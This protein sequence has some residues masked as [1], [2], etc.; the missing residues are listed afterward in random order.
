M[1]ENSTLFKNELINALHVLRCS[2]DDSV[3]LYNYARKL[4]NVNYFNVFVRP[5][6]A[7]A[8]AIGLML[9]DANT[10]FELSSY[11][12]LLEETKPRRFKKNC[13]CQS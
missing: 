9:T 12:P 8:I 10:I 2:A 1:H 13:I 5:Q 7:T 4:Q 3:S 11:L 6:L